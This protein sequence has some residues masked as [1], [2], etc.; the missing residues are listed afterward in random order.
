MCCKRPYKLLHRS[1]GKRGSKH[2]Y[3]VLMLKVE[4]QRHYT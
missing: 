2:K 3:I 4:R 1:K